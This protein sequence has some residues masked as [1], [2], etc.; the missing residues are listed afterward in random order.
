MPDPTP[1]NAKTAAELQELEQEQPGLTNDLIRI[2]L[3]DAPRQMERID[4]AYAARDPEAMRQA[5][6]FLRSGALV[7]GLTSLCEQSKAVELLAP[8]SYGTADADQR[9]SRLGSELGPVL[10][11]LSEQLRG[12]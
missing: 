4:A 11:A 9:I 1:M 5:A 3:A 10:E 7:L 2:F 12:N 6:H 8:E